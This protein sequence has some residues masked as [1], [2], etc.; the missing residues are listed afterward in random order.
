MYSIGKEHPP[1]YDEFLK[2]AKSLQDDKI[3][4]TIKNLKPISQ[5]FGYRIDGSRLRH[6]DEAKLP[7]NLIAFGDSICMFNPFYGQGMTP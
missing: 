7:E 2:F 3:Y 5:I 4:E 6:Y 1:T